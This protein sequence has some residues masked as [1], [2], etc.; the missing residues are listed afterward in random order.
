MTRTRLPCCCSWRLLLGRESFQQSVLK[1]FKYLAV[2]PAPGLRPPQLRGGR[3]VWGYN[4][5]LS[6]L[7]VCGAVLPGA[8]EIIPIGPSRF[9]FQI[10][11][12]QTRKS[13]A[14][15]SGLGDGR[16]TVWERPS[17][18]SNVSEASSVL[19]EPF[20]IVCHS[21]ALQ[22]AQ[23]NAKKQKHTPSCQQENR[24]LLMC[25]FQTFSTH[26]GMKELWE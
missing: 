9:L 10:P 2:E 12:E 24:G 22:T 7:S 11:S 8:S 19:F 17:E 5:G 26:L 4:G 14:L 16:V 1:A 21:Q 18:R 20:Q 25:S 13:P 15:L 23:K 6:G 3:G